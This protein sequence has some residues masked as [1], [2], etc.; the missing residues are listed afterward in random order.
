MCRTDAP[1]IRTRVNTPSAQ[2]SVCRD[3]YGLAGDPGA[4]TDV[5]GASG[6]IRSVIAVPEVS[7]ALN[8]RPVPV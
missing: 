7:V 1:P 8:Y 6:V 4:S 3:A 5:L 2:G